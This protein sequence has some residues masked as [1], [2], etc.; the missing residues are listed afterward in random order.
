MRD[1]L[2]DRLFIP[3]GQWIQQVL[4]IY[5]CVYVCMGNT[6]NFKRCEFEKEWGGSLTLLILKD[7]RRSGGSANLLSSAFVISSLPA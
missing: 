3:K 6:I 5:A 2:P 7:V 1:E 4:F